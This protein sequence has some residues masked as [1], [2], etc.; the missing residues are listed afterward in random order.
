MH[1]MLA[2][3]QLE[4]EDEERE[5]ALKLRLK[6]RWVHPL[7][8]REQDKQLLDASLDIAQREHTDLT[9]LIRE[10]LKEYVTLHSERN[11][12][13]RIDEYIQD[14]T[15]KALPP[16][17]KLLTP[18]ELEEWSDETLLLTARY[19]KARRM[20]LDSE[21]KRRGFLEFRW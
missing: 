15:L 14:P 19:V 9:N 6:P 18:N 2:Y 5:M 13:P 21:L 4:R 11:K 17:T 12:S 3:T 7:N 20:E 16:I 10:S 8:F 1:C